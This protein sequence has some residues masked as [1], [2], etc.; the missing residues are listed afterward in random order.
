MAEG[1]GIVDDQ[2]GVTISRDGEQFR[3]TDVATGET[4]TGDTRPA[5]LRHLADA[6]E[7]RRSIPPERTRAS[8]TVE[9]ASFW[10]FHDDGYRYHA[11]TNP[12]AWAGEEIHPEE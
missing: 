7:Q 12:R 10:E 5:A 3:V 6:I 11:F 9:W 2:E 8:A 4:A 1:S